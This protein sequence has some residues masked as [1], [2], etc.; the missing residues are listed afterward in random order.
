[1]SGPESP[2]SPVFIRK[3]LILRVD[4]RLEE[5]L[6]RG[7]ET[8]DVAVMLPR[9]DSFLQLRY[10]RIILELDEQKKLTG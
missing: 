10:K 8:E 7:S 2:L 5:N 1:M 3:F 4:R 6:R 9:N